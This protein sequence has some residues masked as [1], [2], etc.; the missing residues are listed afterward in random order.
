MEKLE[1]LEAWDPDAA[2]TD[3][4]PTLAALVDEFLAQYVG[5]KANTRRRG[6][7]ENQ[8]PS[9]GTGLP[10]VEHTAALSGTRSTER[11]H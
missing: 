8:R 6:P 2:P 11:K 1:E 9:P 7:D 4:P 3:E 10:A 5:V